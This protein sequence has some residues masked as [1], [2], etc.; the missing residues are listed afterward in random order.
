MLRS[1]V[2]LPPSAGGD[3]GSAAGEAEIAANNMAAPSM[4]VDP[5][6]EAR[7]KVEARGW[8]EDE[9]AIRAQK[10]DALAVVSALA[11]NF[12]LFSTFISLENV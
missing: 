6:L 1:F 12:R 9:A 11:C 5:E 8:E 2:P 10:Q 4:M 3:A 7:A